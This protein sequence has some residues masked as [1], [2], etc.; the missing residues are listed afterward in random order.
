[1]TFIVGMGRSGTTLLTNMLNLNP[2]IIACPENEFVLFTQSA[3]KNKDFESESTVNSFVNLFNYKFSKI[4]SFWK[5]KPEL[6]NSISRLKNKNFANVCKQVYLNYPFAKNSPG[7]ISWI[8][9][10]NP[11]YSLYMDD[12]HQL[13]P[14]SKFIVLTRDFR[15]NVLSRKKFSD[16]K[17]SL[18]TLAVSWNYFYD[19]IFASIHKNKLDYTLLRYEDLVDHPT[20]SL[21]K[22]CAFLHIEF[23][24]QMLHFQD[25]SKDIKSYIKQNLTDSEFSKLTAMHHNLEKTINK[26]RVESYRKELTGYEISILDYIC[27]KHGN[28]FNYK[29]ISLFNPTWLTKIRT[30]MSYIKIKTYYCLHSMSY[31]IPLGIKLLFAVKK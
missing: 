25:L 8:I 14:E 21:Q 18:Y 4:I 2:S 17:S 10:K 29:P 13:F 28:S 19:S 26:D 1:M 5:P 31:K 24:E 22:L 3:F 27:A 23:D 11:I 6:K 20:E 7:K 9:D 12:L 30:W 15:D 16:K